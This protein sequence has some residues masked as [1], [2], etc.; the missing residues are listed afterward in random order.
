LSSPTSGEGY[1]A[2]YWE[3]DGVY[4]FYNIIENVG[5][6][7]HAYTYG[8]LLIMER[9]IP[10]YYGVYDNILIA[11][12]VMTG[13]NGGAHQGWR[14]INATVDG[15]FNNATISNNI[16]YDFSDAAERIQEQASGIAAFNNV[17]ITYNDFYSNGTDAVSWD[18][19]VAY[20][21]RDITTGNIAT[22]PLC[23]GGS[24]FSYRLQISSP[25]IDA[26]IDVGLTRDYDGNIVPAGSAPD[27]G[28][29]EFMS[30]SPPP[31]PTE[32]SGFLKDK[33]GNFIKN[34]SGKI[35]VIQ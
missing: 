15:T 27:I 31:A 32:G 2:H 19:N 23:I 29:Y 10:P 34:S 26:G 1:W 7:D 22:D 5:Y 28:A 13:N 14:G 33:N 18:A 9:D 30:E 20:T 11:N 6:A 8:I 4:V 35:L 12:N 3:W 17:D 16:V 21:N 25:A 24:P